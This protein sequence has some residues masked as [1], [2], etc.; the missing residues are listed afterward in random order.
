MTPRPNRLHALLALAGAMV[1][2]G[3]AVGWLSADGE[4][5]VSA[6]WRGN[7]TS[8]ISA[9]DPGYI[10]QMRLSALAA[11]LDGLGPALVLA[12]LIAAVLLLGVLAWRRDTA[13]A[14]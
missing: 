12:G 3:L 10:E 13:R 7:A 11:G 4:R 1:L 9:Q 14:T 6:Y 5:R 2:G 8:Y